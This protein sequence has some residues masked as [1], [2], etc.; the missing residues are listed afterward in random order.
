MS[1]VPD[2][3]GKTTVH[4]GSFTF[5]ILL[6]PQTPENKARWVRRAEALT[7]LLLTLW[8]KE[9]PRSQPMPESHQNIA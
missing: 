7:E 1:G 2:A 6:A 3:S 4:I 9:Q 5:T 8:R